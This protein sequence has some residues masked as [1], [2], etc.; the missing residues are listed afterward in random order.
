MSKI[1]LDYYRLQT[2][3]KNKAFRSESN[4]KF[5]DTV[6]HIEPFSFFST[7]VYNSSLYNSTE[8][9][10]ILQHEKVHSR[11]YHTVDVL[12][13][14]FFCALFWFNPI[15][16]LYK[17]AIVQNLEFIADKEALKKLED[18]KGYQLTLLKITT[19]ENCISITNH[20]YQSLIKKRIIMLNKNQSKKINSWKYAMVLPALVA[21]VFLFQVKVVAQEKESEFTIQN[22]STSVAMHINSKSTEK[23]LKEENGFFKTT[24]GI[25]LTFTDLKFNSNNEIIAISVRMEDK[26]G[27]NKIYKVNGDKPIKPFDIFVKEDKSNQ[28]TFGFSA[29]SKENL[30][31]KN[32]MDF[33][34]K[35]QN[36]SDKDNDEPKVEMISS[37]SPYPSW[38]ITNATKN[39]KE[40]LIVIDGQKQNK[41]DLIKVDLD[42][43]IA[44]SIT[45]PATLA[46]KKYGADGAN[47]AFEI[48]TKK[49]SSKSSKV[50][51]DTEPT[52]KGWEIK[53]GVSE[54]SY[55]TIKNLSD[56][57]ED[58]DSE[59]K[60]RIA[61]REDNLESV[62]SNI[63]VDYKK[64]V[65]IING[66]VSSV[67]ILNQLKPEQIANISI[68]KIDSASEKSKQLAIQKFGEQ[69]ISGIIY[70]QTKDFLKK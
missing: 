6:D 23:E 7:I 8:L 30:H 20:F 37:S 26:A 62:K 57:K 9:D 4:L 1:I 27:V 69:A 38:S 61:V 16:W 45:L 40:Y 3:L 51:E 32:H 59:A 56:K 25:S 35:Q 22:G 2:I 29:S 67:A 47:G 24:Y 60:Y 10:S 13:T 15:I 64:A 39:G 43:E 34:N 44:S 19:Q 36:K 50:L 12:L 68:E 66:K 17:K 46:E 54:V 33:V 14:R 42:S 11:Q 48:T 63:D 70:V 28:I 52:K 21:F 31:V 41:N 55:N 5:I 53:M 49:N 65:I 18:K 58:K